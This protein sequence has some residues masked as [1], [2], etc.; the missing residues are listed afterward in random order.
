MS[1]DRAQ[2]LEM[3]VRDTV[4]EAC[5]PNLSDL[6]P[7]LAKLDLQ[8]RRRRSAELIGRFYDFFDG[9]I[10][11]RLSAGGGGG[12]GGKEDFL[13]VLLQ[14]HSVDQL[15]LQTIKSFLLVRFL[16]FQSSNLERCP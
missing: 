6:F 10:A 11:R 12:S 3:L 15:S 16:S 8:G 7:V 14:L 4:E 9:I 5:K 13:D 1:S 2:E